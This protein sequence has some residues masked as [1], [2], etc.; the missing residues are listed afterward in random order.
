MSA[1]PQSDLARN[2][3]WKP[4]GAPAVVAASAGAP[5]RA[6]VDTLRESAEKLEAAAGLSPRVAS[7]A[8]TLRRLERRLCRPLRLAVTGEFNAGKSSL[9]NVL[10]GGAI[11]PAL[12]VS[13]T[14]YPTVIGEAAEPE[15]SAEMPGGGR[16]SHIENGLSEWQGAVRLRVGLPNLPFEGLE[17]LDL[18]GSS[19]RLLR[20][21][22]HDVVKHHADAVI[23]C[24]LATQAWKESERA[25]WQGLPQRLRK[26]GLLVATSRDLLRGEKD[27]QRVATRL[28]T[29]SG[30]FRSIVMISSRQAA[31]ARDEKG[32]LVD[33]A[34]W[35]SS[36]A[37]GLE[38][39]VRKLIVQ[40]RR[41]RLEAARHVIER[42]AK[43]AMEGLDA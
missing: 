32:R 20:G 29:I 8:R 38:T 7:A 14:R 31:K 6:L 42:V 26:R 35:Q 21:I 12:A 41:E 39:A 27:Q 34:L 13:N 24:T 37:E 19:D 4:I 10:I 16:I 2:G 22:K 9:A 15:V 43:H 3:L 5:T 11:L 1:L 40:I 28:A 17:I 30:Q 18:P 36:G 25:A 23:W 33:I